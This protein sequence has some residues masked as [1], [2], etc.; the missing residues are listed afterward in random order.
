MTAR[1]KGTAKASSTGKRLNVGK[2]TLKDL[3]APGAG[4]KGG[5]VRLSDRCR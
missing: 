2:K 3:K 5:G 4:P 1:K